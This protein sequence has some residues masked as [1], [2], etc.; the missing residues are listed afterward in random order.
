MPT[1]LESS[2]D[3][4]PYVNVTK[5]GMVTAIGNKLINMEEE[6]GLCHDHMLDTKKDVDKVSVAES[7]C[8]NSEERTLLKTELS[9]PSKEDINGAAAPIRRRMDQL[10]RYTRKSIWLLVYIAIV[11]TWPLVGS[12]LLV[13]LKRKF[14]NALPAVLLSR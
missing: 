14:R 4:A 13:T 12:A 9:Q 6:E 3:Q 2:I 5:E 8:N 11:T 1:P 7:S 10:S